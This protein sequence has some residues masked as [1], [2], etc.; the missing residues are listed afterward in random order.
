MCCATWSATISLGAAYVQAI[1][2]DPGLAKAQAHLGLSFKRQGRLD[3]A[4]VCLKRASELDPAEPDFAEFL[5]DFYVARLDFLEAINCYKRAIAISRVEKA[6]LHLSLGWALQEHG[7]LGEAHE[8]YREA[9]RIQPGLATVFTHLGGYHE[10]RGELAQAEA[11]YRR[12]LELQP[13]NPLPLALLG[14]LL[15]GQLP[16][17]DLAALE[18]RLSG[19]SVSPDIRARLAFALGQVLD[20][21]GDYTRASKWIREANALTLES[22][23]GQNDFVPADHERFVD[24]VIKHFDAAFFARTTGMGSESRRP[25]FIFGLP[26]SGTS[27][28]E[29]VLASHSHVHGAGELRLGRQSFEAIPLV[30]GRNAH[31]MECIADLD[32]DSIRRLAALHLE[33]LKRTGAGRRR[34]SG[35]Q[36]AGQLYVCRTH[37]NSLSQGR[38]PSLPARPS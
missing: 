13:S 10:E 37:E 22:R 24:N 3:E 2:L 8:E 11:D 26:R 20:A 19:E 1:R 33:R 9:Q 35:R 16:D 29:Q 32:A 30:T 12:G 27:L 18:Q 4:A 25:V 6:G 31:P 21:R 34:A 23:R 5:G 7:R 17:V 15:R 36:D 14:T 28:I 38:F